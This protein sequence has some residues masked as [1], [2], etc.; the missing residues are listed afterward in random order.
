MCKRGGKDW[1]L[2]NP[3]SQKCEVQSPR[4]PCGRMQKPQLMTQALVACRTASVYLRN[5]TSGRGN[6]LLVPRRACRAESINV[7]SMRTTAAHGNKPIELTEAYERATSRLREH[8][9]FEEAG[10]AFRAARGLG[11]PGVT[12]CCWHALPNGAADLPL[13]AHV[14]GTSSRPAIVRWSDSGIRVYRPCISVLS[15][16]TSLHPLSSRPQSDYARTTASTRHAS[17]VSAFGAVRCTA[18]RTRRSLCRRWMMVV[19]SLILRYVPNDPHPP[20]W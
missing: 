3:D 11:R 14:G 2:S 18:C 7:V 9:D 16:V 19:S 12:R 10:G 1:S 6:G 15:I 17:T 20:A 8:R 13:L 4:H 5:G